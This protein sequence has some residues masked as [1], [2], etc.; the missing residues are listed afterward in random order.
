MALL[1]NELF[2]IYLDV[3]APSTRVVSRD[4]LNSFS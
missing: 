1:R 3:I 4:V 2:S